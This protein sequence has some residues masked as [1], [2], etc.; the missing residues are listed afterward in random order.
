[1]NGQKLG[2]RIYL[3]SYFGHSILVTAVTVT[4]IAHFMA[5]TIQSDFSFKGLVP[6]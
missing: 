4:V 5:D 6:E 2:R 3:Q 1:M